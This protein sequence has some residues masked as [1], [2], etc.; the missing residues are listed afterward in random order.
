MQRGYAAAQ[1]GEGEYVPHFQRIVVDERAHAAHHRGHSEVQ[2]AYQTAAVDHIGDC[3]GHQSQ[4]EERR[5]PQ[6]KRHAHHERVVGYL[7]HKPAYDDLLAHKADGVE[8]R[9]GYKQ[10]KVAVAQRGRA[11]RVAHDGGGVGRDA[12]ASGHM[13]NGAIMNAYRTM[14]NPKGGALSLFT[15]HREGKV[16]TGIG[17]PY[18][19]A[20]RLCAFALNAA[21]SRRS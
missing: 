10:P 13:H 19:P 21:V 1:H 17:Q 11:Q 18:P 6:P 9:R 2:N 4:K 12:G 8:E 20:L 7:K 5:K 15:N 14:H 3:A 16:R